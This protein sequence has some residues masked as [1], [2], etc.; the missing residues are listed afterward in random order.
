MAPSALP[1][2]AATAAQ[3]SVAAILA[4]ALFIAAPSSAPAATTLP[5]KASSQIPAPAHITP[6]TRATPAPAPS[7]VPPADF[8][9]TAFGEITSSTLPLENGHR[10]AMRVNGSPITWEDFIAHVRLTGATLYEKHPDKEPSIAA[11]LAAAV[12][13]GLIVN[14]LYRQFAAAHNLEPEPRE[15]QKATGAAL[16]GRDPRLKSALRLLNPDQIKTLVADNLAREKVDKYLGDR[17]T[18]A[19]PTAAELTSFTENMRPT[20]SPVTVLRARHIVIRATP[21]MSEFNTNDAKAK[22]DEI[23]ARIA[24]GETSAPATGS[25]LLDFPAAAR[26]FSQDRFTAYRGGDLGY[27]KAGT[28]YP[29]V[30]D[31]LEKLQPGQVSPVVRTAVGFHIFQLTERHPDDLRLQYDKFRREQAIAHWKTQ[32]GDAAKIENYLTPR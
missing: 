29:P 32:T 8:D 1:A 4:A 9:P 13:D 28:M 19:P 3:H 10:I 12:K 11:T 6:S 24:D 7:A 15:I 31:A 20:T 21:D 18:S 14:A 17:A 25:T 23:R 5:P 26:Q 16:S 30:N 27:F 2:P 22:A